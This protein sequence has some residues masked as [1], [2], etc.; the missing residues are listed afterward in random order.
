MWS[1]RLSLTS[2]IQVHTPYVWQGRNIF[3]KNFQGASGKK[4]RRISDLQNFT[5][6]IS[7]CR[8]DEEPS[9]VGVAMRSPGN[10]GHYSPK[11]GS[12][13]GR[14]SNGSQKLGG[15]GEILRVCTPTVPYHHPHPRPLLPSEIL[16]VGVNLGV[17]PPIANNQAVR[18]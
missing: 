14:N 11:V 13:F 9:T 12:H 16:G 7:E 10:E 8:G 17:W 5:F 18:I 6:I 15:D 1:D 4:F 3:L 2:E